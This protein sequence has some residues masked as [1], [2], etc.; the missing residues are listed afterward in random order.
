MASRGARPVAVRAL[1]RTPDS[2]CLEWMRPRLPRRWLTRC[3]SVLLSGAPPQ[4]GA[5]ITA[6]QNHPD[7]WTRVDAI[8]DRSSS[9]AT[10]ILAANILQETVKTRWKIL[11]QEQR[12]GIKAYV[13][14]LIIKLSSDLKTL[15]DNRVF[16]TKLNGVLVQI[17]K[18]EWPEHW[19]NFIPELVNSSKTSQSLCANNMNI[20]LLMSEE[21]FDFRSVDLCAR[22]FPACELLV[23][24][25]G[26]LRFCVLTAL[27]PHFVS[28]SSSSGQMTQEKM[29]TM[30]Q[31]L[32][33]EF[34]LIF[35][36]V[37][38]ILDNSNEPTLLT[39][40]L[41]TLLRF[42]HWIPIGYIFETKLISTLALKFFPV[43]QFHTDALKCLSEIGSLKLKEE[44]PTGTV[45]MLPGASAANDAKYNSSFV[46]LFLA[47]ISQACKVITPETDIAAVW[48]QGAPNAQEFIRHLAIFITSY[49][50]S[51][52]SL[53]ESESDQTRAALGSS[54][55]ILLRISR[56]DDNEVFK[57][58]LE[59]W[60]ILVTDLYNTQRLYMAQHGSRLLGQQ[61]LMSGFGITG[62][63][64]GLT[65]MGGLL[66]SGL[67]SNTNSPRLLMYLKPLQELRYVMI[68]KMARPE[69]VLIVEEEGEIIRAPMKD[70]DA[71][72]LY[73]SM[74]EALIYLTHLDP[75][76]AQETMLKKLD[77]QVDTSEKSEWG[78][79][80]LNTLCWAI[81]SISGALSEQQEKTFLV[82]VIRDLLGLCEMKRGKDHKAV[83]ASNI[84]YVVGQYPRFLRMH[85]KFLKTVVNKLIE[86]MHESQ[87]SKRNTA[88][89]S[90]R[91]ATRFALV[92][93]LIRFSPIAMFL[94]RQ[95]T[96]VS[97][98]CR[99]TR[100]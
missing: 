59:Y 84:M 15:V 64:P 41:Q 22:E 24:S 27:F 53:V 85:W 62:E 80:A 2:T 3:C 96:P 45:Q 39:A 82:R 91:N 98:T 99:S 78:W 38:Y 70:T 20:L 67:S 36:L 18:Q 77:A 40:T 65:P 30:K 31:N 87:S 100:S 74:R 23:D 13:V 26:M 97:R 29:K 6:F 17:V 34:T 88:W 1:P 19:P 93:V 58:C 4:I 55:Q 51:H 81:G 21:V 11:P 66:N 25:R 35:Q 92:L 49:L 14:N 44:G 54:I 37:E 56:V 46:N 16:L 47:V 60:I 33:R 83:I 61:G 43:Q 12:A 71:L 52:I 32:N 94:S 10:R 7:S 57:V 48:A 42:L 9:P 95:P 79:N 50:K 28:L 89:A 72:I 68:S 75:N 8:L 5:V 76:D 86:F 69:E 73:R 90:Y 63:K